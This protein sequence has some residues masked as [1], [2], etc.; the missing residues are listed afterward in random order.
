[1]FSPGKPPPGAVAPPRRSAYWR[2]WFLIG[3]LLWLASVGVT[4]WTGNTYLLPTVVLLGSFLVPS[5]FVI[6]AHERYA[7]DIGDDHIVACFAVGG[8]IGVLGAS[9]LE[10]YLLA[11]ANVGLYAGIG[12]IEEAVKLGALALLSRNLP[13][14]SMRV[15]M[16]LGAAVGHG[17]AAFESA[18]Y[19]FNAVVTEHS[20]S[21]REVVSTE[22]L[23]GVLAPIGH[24]LWTSIL[25]A[26]LFS[27]RRDGRFRFT[28][29]LLW[30]YLG[31]SALHAFWDSTHGLA[32]WITGRLTV[33]DWSYGLFDRGYI[34]DP[35]HRQVELQTFFSWAG[36]ALCG[37]VGLLWLW[38]LARRSRRYSPG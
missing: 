36:L 27:T 17:F 28:W 6:W 22:V 26:V 31:V 9:V 19:A 25:G 13:N 14:Y 7:A 32:V 18:G 12:L 3:L 38:W 33:P 37:V 23:R 11:H 8:V 4:Y 34:Q 30:S 35:T 20:L 21:L 10:Y 2:S 5:S 16:V 29:A 1:V 15:G 24:G